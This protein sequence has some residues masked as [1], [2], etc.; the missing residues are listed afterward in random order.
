MNKS[1]TAALM[2]SAALWLTGCSAEIPEPKTSS[3]A[4]CDTENVDPLTIEYDPNW[5]SYEVTCP[6]DRTTAEPALT[7]APISNNLKPC[8]LIETSADRKR[9]Q[10]ATTGFPRT[11]SSTR[12]ADGAHKVMVIPVDWPDLKEDVDPTTFLNPAAEKYAKWF[13]AN[14]NGKVSM[15]MTVYPSWITLPKESKNYGQDEKQQVTSQ[16]GDKNRTA[17]QRFWFDAL[18]AADP[19][20]DFTGVDIVFFV[21]PRSQTVF[22]EFNL[23]PDGTGSF[24]TKEAIIK[25]GFTPGEF[26]FRPGN[27]LWA[28]WAH[29]SMHYFKLPDLYWNDQGST[30]KESF[31]QYTLPAPIYGY[32][33][34]T[35]YSSKSLNMWLKWLV[36]WAND[37]QLQCVTN[38]SFSEGSYRLTPAQTA[39]DSLHA[40]MLKISKTKILVIESHRDTEFDVKTNRSK[41]GAMIYVVD[42]SLS[43]GQGA[44]TL[45]APEGRTL[46]NVENDVPQLDAIF[47]EGNRLDIAGYHI[48]VNQSDDSGETVSIS[49]SATNGAVKY[50]C[51]T[52]ENRDREKNSSLVCPLKL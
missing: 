17:V 25:R 26:H 37:S 18:S 44:V 13:E 24:K 10:D 28:F 15:Q 47:Y 6:T 9:Y 46:Y 21:A 16:W 45:I 31:S 34:M 4:S 51:V 40:V 23:W 19:Y 39:D 49:R 29:E 38:D 43:H 30:V 20:V 2:I 52:L 50:V 14:T 42:T 36:G 7:A 35:N 22:H 32:D 41:A 33:L 1:K 12:L 48:T 27:E 5:H 3:P 8:Q 11:T